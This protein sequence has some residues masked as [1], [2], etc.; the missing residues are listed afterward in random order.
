MEKI[1]RI[2]W[3]DFIIPIAILA[4]FTLIFRFT[5]LDLNLQAQF[6]QKGTG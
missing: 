4:V 3:L 6:W 1:N 5:D 2:N